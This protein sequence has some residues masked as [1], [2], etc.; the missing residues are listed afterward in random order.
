M[1]GYKFP[2]NESYRNLLVKEDGDT[3]ICH[4]RVCMDEGEI[5]TSE[6]LLDVENIELS[7][8]NEEEKD[9]LRDANIHFE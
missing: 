2:S 1:E 5:I 3:Y 4:G 9:Y 8:L 6:T 7:G